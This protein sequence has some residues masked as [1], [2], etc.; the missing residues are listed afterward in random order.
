M[1]QKNDAQYRKMTQTPVGRLVLTMAVPTMIAMLVTAVYNMVDTFFVSKLGTSASGAV[2]ILFSMMALIQAVGFTI[3]MG[4]GAQISRLLGKKKA[5]EANEV[6]ASAVISGLVM[7]G[8][9]AALGVCFTNPIVE[10]LGATETILPYACEYGRYI[11]LAAP[12]MI[13]CFILNNLLRA[14]GKAKYSMFG[15]ISG[16]LLNIALDPLFLFVFRM[17]LGG[18]AIATA[19]SQLV[20][21]GFLFLP[22]L[23]K[24]TVLSLHFKNI[25]RSAA[26]YGRILKFG[27]PSLFRQG[28]ASVASVLLN[29]SAALY[30]DFA[31]AAMSIV[32]KVF[33]VLFSVLIGFGQ[34]YQPVA[35]YNYG[36]KEYSR[37]RDAFWFTL[38]VAT[39]GMVVFAVAAYFFAPELIAVFLKE[40]RQVVT[41]GTQAL[42]MQ[43]V[44][45]PFMALG[46]VCNMTFQAIGRSVAAT[47]LTSMR[48]GIFFVP[49]IWL[50]PKFFGLIGLQ[51]AQPAADI[52]TFVFCIPYAVVFLK[53]MKK[54][55]ENPQAKA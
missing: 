44:A 42:R 19:V 30:G 21:M 14:E 22:Y 46:I 27:T 39:A 32:A 1:G 52:I 33:M 6:A 16:G 34:G 40:D 53:N 4:A 7:G 55:Q 28:F 20:G 15:I 37:V 18:A 3:G 43:S 41:I 50:L 38:K 24:K 5:E 29:R 23:R 45:M 51:A 12:V 8:V 48:Q 25:S 26:V 54:A 17:G 36:A 31:V 11:F 13:T 10:M 2:G 49:L 47:F 35:G 9:I